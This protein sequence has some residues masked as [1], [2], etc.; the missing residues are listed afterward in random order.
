MSHRK[1]PEQ[2]VG[3]HLEK[4]AIA[5]PSGTPTAW[6]KR[7]AQHGGVSTLLKL[8]LR[9]PGQVTFLH[10]EFP[11]FACVKQPARPGAEGLDKCVDENL[12]PGV[13]KSA[14]RSAIGNGK[15]AF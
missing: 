9:V 3:S 7:D 5:D 2:T 15:T 4:A 6:R 12:C 14:F 8:G 11:A 1:S 13:G 10:L